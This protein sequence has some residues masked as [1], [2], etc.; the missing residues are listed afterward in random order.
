ML[1]KSGADPNIVMEDKRTPLHIASEAGNTE[2]IK[3]L[4]ENDADI[5]ATDQVR[6]YDDD[7]DDDNDDDVS[8]GRDSSSPVSYTHLTLPTKA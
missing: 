8:G 3:L 6:L 4:L 1:L 2:V 7:N 5:L